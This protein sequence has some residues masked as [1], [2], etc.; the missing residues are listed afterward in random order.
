M[1]TTQ[2][3]SALFNRAKL[4]NIGAKFANFHLQEKCNNQ[5]EIDENLCLVFHDIDM[6]PLNPDLQ[7]NCD[8]R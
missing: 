3:D 5:T 7:Y 2:D 8:K 6:L 1:V 4:M